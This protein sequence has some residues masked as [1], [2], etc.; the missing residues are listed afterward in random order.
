[1]HTLLGEQLNN[2][3]YVH[4]SGIYVEP[5]DKPREMN[6]D[7]VCAV[8]C[9]LDLLPIIIQIQKHQCRMRRRENV[10]SEFW[11]EVSRIFSSLVHATMGFKQ[12]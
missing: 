10:K 2:G 1:M 3:C 7:C 5:T 9:N 11:T 12:L 6:G 8:F 4:F